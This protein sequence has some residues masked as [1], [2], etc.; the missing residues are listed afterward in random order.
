VDWLLIGKLVRWTVVAAIVLVILLL[1]GRWLWGVLADYV[2]PKT[3]ADRKDLVSIFVLIAAGVVGALTAI[4]A[5]GNLYVSRRNL[6]NARETL[7]QQRNLDERRAQDDAL[8]AY[9][10][11]IGK[12]LTE[13][14]LRN[15]GIHD[16]TR[17]L[18][19]AQ[20]STVLRRLDTSRKAEL[21]L[22]LERAQLI[23]TDDPLVNLVRADLYGVDLSGQVLMETS[24]EYANLSHANL[25]G[26]DISMSHVS[27]TVLSHADLSD[28]NLS[29]A[30]L[31]HADLRGADLSNA[32][33]LNASLVYADLSGADL[34]DANGLRDRDV[35]L[36]RSLKGTTM[37]N[38]QKYE[39]WLKDKEGRREDAENT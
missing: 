20:T 24:L 6:Q 27:G 12:M 15:S 25:R 33:L 9:Y 36:M 17:L 30:I 38:G 28:A 14:G 26:A 3:A 2:A 8:Q 4:A 22:F 31:S 13:Q 34:T 32:K 16:D 23:N 7:R 21:V 29:H 10:E 39:D 1:V 35:S 19:E 11:Q 5:V 18:A 37:P